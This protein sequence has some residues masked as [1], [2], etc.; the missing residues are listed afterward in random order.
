MIKDSDSGERD[1]KV[2]HQAVIVSVTNVALFKDG[3]Y[4]SGTLVIYILLYI[5][6]YI[7]YKK[8][9]CFDKNLKLKKYS[10]KI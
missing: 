5:T 7:L 10:N 8:S 1:E 3:D 2:F 6:I 9:K 4:Y